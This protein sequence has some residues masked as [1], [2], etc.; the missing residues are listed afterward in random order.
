VSALVLMPCGGCK[1]DREAPLDELYTGPLWQTLRTY[2]GAIPRENVCVLSAKYGFENAR[3]FGAPYDERLSADKAERMLDH[4]VERLFENAGRTPAATVGRGPFST[5]I[6]AG[7]GHYRRVMESYVAG[8]Q[9][10]GI[11]DRDACVRTVEG[12][13][14][15]QRSQLGRWLIELNGGAP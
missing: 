9:R 8:F 10:L 5:V 7:A 13:I 2:R 3:T 1:L 14:G 6:I 12:G 15:E 11:V 4:G